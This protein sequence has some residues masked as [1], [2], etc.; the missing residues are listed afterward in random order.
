[1]MSF[2]A[3]AL[4]TKR[5]TTVLDRIDRTVGQPPIPSQGVEGHGMA[6]E[7]AKFVDAWRFGRWL[8][9][10]IGILAGILG[11]GAAAYAHLSH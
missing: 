6:G 8:W 4:E 3:M 1:M 5:Q 9:M 7:F 10:I 11:G 2:D